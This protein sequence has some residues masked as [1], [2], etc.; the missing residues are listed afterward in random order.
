MN[1][2][3]AVPP[4]SDEHSTSAV[5]S[6][7][8]TSP[9]GIP[10][11]GVA[12]ALEAPT[13]PRPTSPRSTTILVDS[14]PHRLR[15]TED[16]LD[17]AATI[18]SV[19]AVLILAIYAHQTTTGVTQD[20]QNALAVVLRQILILPLQA[21][22][23]LVTFAIPLAVLLDHL[24]RGSW[25]GAGE[26]ALAGAAGNLVALAF[27][28]TLGTWGPDSLVSGL[29]VTASGTA[30]LGISTVF[31]TLAGLLTGAGDRRGS[32]VVR[33]GWAALW[34]ITGLAVLRSALTLPG[35]VLS[36]LLGRV[37]G[38]VMRYA[39]GVN[40]RRA[41][42]VTLVRAL[43]RAGVDAT[44]LVR[45][46]YSPTSTHLPARAWKVTTDAPLGYTEQVREN[47]CRPPT[48]HRI[49]PQPA[50]PRGPQDLPAR[51]PPSTTPSWAPPW[52]PSCWRPPAQPC[53]QGAPPPTAPTRRGTPQVSAATLPCWTPTA[54]WSAS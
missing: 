41:Q 6:T 25:R 30:Q 21:V 23:G 31:A 37:V 8:A 34:T 27:L 13:A 29:T 38:L 28:A 45:T 5:A 52:T 14:P 11:I 36:V 54:R 4:G 17:L 51:S 22:E 24:L 18:L 26:A 40:D 42:G 53:R 2:V 46:D 50:R 19:G 43:R 10:T 1:D 48:P 3:D 44:H 33:T 39:V 16:L 32:P 15:R 35:A 12:P 9:V 49:L 7:P 20:V 47:P